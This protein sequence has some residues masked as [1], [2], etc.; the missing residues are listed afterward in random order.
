MLAHS[1]RKKLWKDTGDRR[2]IAAVD[3]LGLDLW[4]ACPRC[5]D[6]SEPGSVACTACGCRLVER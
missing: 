5:G 2:N 3:K 4:P 6:L 1:L